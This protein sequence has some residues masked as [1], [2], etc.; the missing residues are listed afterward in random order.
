MTIFSSCTLNPSLSATEEKLLN[1]SESLMEAYPDSAMHVLESIDRPKIQSQALKARYALLMSMAMDKNY[2]DTTTFDVLQPAIDYYIEKDKGNTDEKLRTYYYQGRIFQNAGYVDNALGCFIKGI[3]IAGDDNCSLTLARTYVATGTIYKQLYNYES[4]S[5]CYSK[6]AEIYSS[7]SKPELELECKLIALIGSIL[8]GDKTKADSLINLCNQIS[9]RSEVQRQAKR[10]C[11]ISYA[12]EYGTDNEIEELVNSLTPDSITDAGGR[13]SMAY[14][15]SKIGHNEEA[16]RYLNKVAESSESYDTLRHIALSVGA[17]EELGYYKEALDMYYKYNEKKDSIDLTRFKYKTESI[18]DRY[19]QE[20]KISAEARYKSRI[21]WGCVGGLVILMLSIVILMLIIRSNR[22][23]KNLA[24]EKAR[25]SELE[26]ERLKTDRGKLAEKVNELENESLR[27]RN[28][29]EN[30][31]K[32]PEEIRKAIQ[33]RIEM[34]NSLL[35]GHITNNDEYGRTYDEWVSE[36]TENTEEFMNSNRMAFQVSHPQFIK[37]FEDHGLTEKEINYVCMYA[38]GLR[39][40]EV[41]N[42]MN[43]RSHVNMS[44]TIRKKLGIDKHSTNIGIYVRKK[45]KE[46]SM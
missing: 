9:P 25:S 39:G 11:Y 16:L 24:I 42:Y 26:N 2:I 13:L 32:I 7:K 31:D 17:L 36:I 10:N 5:K 23:Q 19:E 8:V 18:K 37:F 3:D 34:L 22:I 45:L 15:S 38:I 14:A 30:S 29:L 33:I 40:K 20:L 4:Y 27:L 12:V 46:L 41:G 44:S 21:I 35:A 6:A 28:L 1:Q 43:M